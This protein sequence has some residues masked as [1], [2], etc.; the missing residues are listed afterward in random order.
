MWR[1]K[2]KLDWGCDRRLWTLGWGNGSAWTWWKSQSEYRE[3]KVGIIHREQRGLFRVFR[4]LGIRA[5]RSLVPIT[6]FIVV[7]QACG[8]HQKYVEMINNLILHRRF[9]FEHCISI[10][11]FNPWRELLLIETLGFHFPLMGTDSLAMHGRISK[12]STTRI[13]YSW[14][15]LGGSSR[16]QSMSRIMVLGRWVSGIKV[17]S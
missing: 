12:I 9:V 5:F 16:F 1:S 4:V 13:H 17:H 11:Q 3:E 6:P 8:V 2:V 10:S 7:F 14:T 15:I